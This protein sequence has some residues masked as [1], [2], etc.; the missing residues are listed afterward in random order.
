MFKLGEAY[1]E[2]NGVRYNWK[3]AIFWLEQTLNRCE[4]L[5]NKPTNIFAK[6]RVI[7]SQI[8]MNKYKLDKSAEVWL[9][10][11]LGPEGIKSSSIGRA[12]RLYGEATIANSSRAMIALSNMYA[13]GQVIRPNQ[14]IAF[15]WFQQAVKQ[16][17]TVAIIEVASRYEKGLGVKSDQEMAK[18]FY[19]EAPQKEKQMA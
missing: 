13:K 9:N 1:Y 7:L 18:K 4:N 10:N 11:A 15:A 12:I 16:G 14:K 2:G 3:K 17:N 5:A 19:K 6:A 8:Y